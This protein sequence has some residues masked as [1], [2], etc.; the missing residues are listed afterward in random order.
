MKFINTYKPN[1]AQIWTKL[2]RVIWKMGSLVKEE[3]FQEKQNQNKIC[4]RC[5]VYKL[6]N[7]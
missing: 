3:G 4:E 7:A 6:A 5:W 2:H 1:H